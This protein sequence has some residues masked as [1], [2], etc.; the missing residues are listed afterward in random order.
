MECDRQWPRGG[1]ELRRLSF[2]DI[3]GLGE[4]ARDDAL[5]SGRF[6]L[7]HLFQHRQKMNV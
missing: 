7:R 1:D 6:R 3:V 5:G 2:I 4:R